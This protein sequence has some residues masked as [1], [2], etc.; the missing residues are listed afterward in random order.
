MIEFQDRD[1]NGNYY[2]T[3]DPAAAQPERKKVAIEKTPTGIMVNIT[4]DEAKNF[5]VF[6]RVTTENRRPVTTMEKV[7]LRQ[8]GLQLPIELKPGT[9]R[10][11]VVAKNVDSAAIEIQESDFPIIVP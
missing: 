7:M 4:L 5:N 10:V 6:L 9:Y 1:H 3:M 2:M 8:S 11:F